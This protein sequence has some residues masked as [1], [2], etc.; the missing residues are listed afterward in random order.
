MIANAPLGVV[1][2]V[3]ASEGTRP[4]PG[5]GGGVNCTPPGIFAK[6]QSPVYS[7]Y[8][9]N[10]IGGN[11]RITG[12]NSCW[13]GG[14][15]NKVGGSVT[16]RTTPWPT[17]TPTEILTSPFRRQPPLLRT[18]RPPSSTGTPDGSPNVVGGFATGQCAFGVK[19]PKPAPC[20]DRAGTRPGL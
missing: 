8:E 12:L 19:Q 4:R 15:R 10:T 20:P 6:F 17:P 5:G 3:T 16:Y 11:L 18:T 14:L 9:D 13:L 1:V 7:D 2:H